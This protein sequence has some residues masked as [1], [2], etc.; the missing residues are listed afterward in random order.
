MKPFLE[1]MA[2]DLGLSGSVKFLGDVRSEMLGQ[3][4]ASSDIFVLP[5]LHAESFG[6]VLLEAM[7][8]EVP[9]IASKTGGVPEVVSDGKEGI[10]VKPG[11]EM[12]LSE[13]LTR[14]LTN[15]NERSEMGRA[16]RKKALKD[17]DWQVVGGKIEELYRSLA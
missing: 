17:Y 12:E 7:A 5:S 16:G 6:I 8:S 1:M 10:L 9:V 4:Y 11:D 13:A 3:T 14:L 15:E 2:Y